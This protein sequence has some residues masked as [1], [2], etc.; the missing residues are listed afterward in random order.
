MARNQLTARQVQ[1]ARDGDYS[2]GDGLTL[3]VTS[4]RATWVFRFTSPTGKRREQ[5]LGVCRRSNI[6]EAGRSLTDARDEAEKSR[7]LLRDKIDPIDKAKADRAKAK[8]DAEAQR[9]E[10]RAELYTLARAARA[11]YEQAFEPK[12]KNGE[13]LPMPYSKKYSVGWIGALEKHVPPGI[14]HK[15]MDAIEPDELFDFFVSIRRGRAEVGKRVARRLRDIFS[16]AEDQKL[17][18]GNPAAT[19]VNRIKRKKIR[20]GHKSESFAALPFDEVPA[21]V[22]ELRQREAIAAKALLFGVYTWARTG[23]IIGARWS[24]FRGLEGDDP[25][26]IVPKG[27]MK[28]GGADHTVY[29]SPSAVAILGEARQWESTFVFPSPDSVGSDKPAPLSNMAMLTLLRRMD[30]DKRTT[31]HGLCRQSSSTWANETGAA[32]PD[33]IEACLAHN[34]A[35]L[36]RAAYNKAKYATER[37]ELLRAWAEFVDGRMKG[38]SVVT[39]LRRKAA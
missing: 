27:R 26:W 12:D 29:L 1:V 39:P 34:E 25:R 4:A 22:A 13:P 30:Q 37:R 3:R 36:V 17:C 11:Y 31:V 33:V 21:F 10:Q 9:Q 18:K 20:F 5:G 16:D 28:M 2:D 8:A 23:E 19:A 7:R 24:E 15:P 14:W 32:R 6:T 38:R 35:D